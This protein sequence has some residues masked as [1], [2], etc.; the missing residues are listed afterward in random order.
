MVRAAGGRGC[1]RPCVF[2]RRQ[3]CKRRKVAGASGGG[4][5]A[6]EVEK[7]ILYL[8]SAVLYNPGIR[9]ASRCGF[10]PRYT[11]HLPTP[12]ARRSAPL[13]FSSR[14]S[15]PSPLLGLHRNSFYFLFIFLLR[16]RS[17][18]YNHLLHREMKLSVRT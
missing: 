7:N 3:E 15:I 14:C 12:N 16:F 13:S 8:A 1:K 5:A 6:A 11:V 10:I 17:C 4:V 9:L 2:E 18:N